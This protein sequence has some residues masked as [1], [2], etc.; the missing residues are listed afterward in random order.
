MNTHSAQKGEI[1]R[2]WFVVDASDKVLGRM[3]SQVA[4]ILKGKHTPLYTPSIDTG[5]FVIVIN[6]EKVKLTGSKEDKKMYYRVGLQGLPGSLKVRSA[7]Q[8]RESR[9]EDLVKNAV[10][11]MLPRN[12]LGRKM[13]TKLKV[14]A[15]PT[16]PHEAQQPQALEIRA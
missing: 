13:F 16:H 1:R 2:K 15:G 3:S 4:S 12:A 11:R 5:D 6:A 9:P 10:R 7:K 8:L 14:Y